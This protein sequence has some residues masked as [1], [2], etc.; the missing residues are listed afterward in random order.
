MRFSNPDLPR[1]TVREADRFR[2]TP[3]SV[4]HVAGL[5]DYYPEARKFFGNVTD[6]G[7]IPFRRFADKR[8]SPKHYN[9]AGAIMARVMWDMV[10][11]DRPY[12]YS[13][14]AATEVARNLPSAVTDFETYHDFV[15]AEPWRIVLVRQG[16]SAREMQAKTVNVSDFSFATIDEYAWP[17]CEFIPVHG[18]FR[19]TLLKYADWWAS[20]IEGD[21]THRAQ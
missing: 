3:E 15:A 20:D 18:I 8:T 9:L 2:L 17:F 5:G 4:I 14:V 6:R 16:P 7:L 1:L 21:G 13:R 11:R 12:E 10:R 19:T